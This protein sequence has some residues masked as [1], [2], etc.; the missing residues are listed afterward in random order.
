M[1]SDREQPRGAGDSVVATVTFLSRRASV[2]QTCPAYTRPW[3]QG[4]HCRENKEFLSV[5]RREGG[6]SVLCAFQ[7]GVPWSVART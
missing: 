4:Q 1:V 5:V 7:C 3:I 6:H 2:Y